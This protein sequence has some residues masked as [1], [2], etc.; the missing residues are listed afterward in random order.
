MLAKQQTNVRQ[1]NNFCAAIYVSTIFHKSNKEN[2][3]AK[4]VG[5]CKNF[6][7]AQGWAFSGDLFVRKDET[8]CIDKLARARA[9]SQCFDYIISYVS[10]NS[11]ID[12][13]ACL[14]AQ[15]YA[16]SKAPFCKYDG[17]K[18]A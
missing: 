13:I 5:A 6:I 12:V 15:T 18:N 8:A 4:Q 3:I 9:R 14:D 2:N 11:E 7:D 16:Y 10:S 17:D 1:L